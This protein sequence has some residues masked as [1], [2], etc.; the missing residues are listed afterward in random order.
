MKPL[1]EEA[2]QII[3]EAERKLQTLLGQRISLAIAEK[4]DYTHLDVLSAVFKVTGFSFPQMNVRKRSQEPKTARQLYLY[5]MHKSKYYTTLKNLG[6]EFGF[7]HTTVKHNIKTIEDLLDA[8]DEMI[9]RLVS[10]IKGILIY[11]IQVS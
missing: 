3:Y 10:E 8:K 1:N 2:L 11:D 4:F 6:L 9:T 7:D 5:F